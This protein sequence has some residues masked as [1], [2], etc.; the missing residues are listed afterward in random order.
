MSMTSMPAKQRRL[1]YALTA[2]ITDQAAACRHDASTRAM[3]AG[4]DGTGI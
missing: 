4:P 3:S 2:G 1:I